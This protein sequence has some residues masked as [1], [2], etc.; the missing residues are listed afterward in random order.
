MN[1]VGGRKESIRLI[2]DNLK[3]NKRNRE[4]EAQRYSTEKIAREEPGYTGRNSWV[5]GWDKGERK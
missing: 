1:K 2:N 3:Q 4:V 5:K